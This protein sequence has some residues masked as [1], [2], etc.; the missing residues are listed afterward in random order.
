VSKNERRKQV[1]KFSK[2]I[3]A[4]YNQ[5][6]SLQR[7]PPLLNGTIADFIMY[8]QKQAMEEATIRTKYKVY[9]VMLRDKVNLENP[10][11]VKLYIARRKQWSTGHK[12]IAC[13]AYNDYAKM[14][15]IQWEVPYY[16]KN[17]TLPI[18]PTE[19]EIDALIA[20]TSRK[21]SVTLQALKE[22]GF[23]IGELYSCKWT[24]LDEEKST[25][26]CVSEK[27]GRPREAKIS[28]RLLARIN[29]LPRNGLLIFGTK[30]IGG[31]RWT[32]DK[33]KKKLAEKLQNPRLTQIHFHTM[34]HYYATKVYNETKSIIEVQAKLGHRNIN[35]T[36]VYTHIMQFDEE[37]QNYHHAVARD[38]KEAGELI[39]NG[40]TYILTTPQN[41]M[42]FRKRK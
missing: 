8:C 38:E 16:K 18:V 4:G 11:E 30:N 2:P 23:R 14:R 24:D 26:R 17:E 15:R 31:I 32:L 7:N 21:V 13:Y 40:W 36:M 34:R 20:G 9:K 39:D 41:I 6:T 12:I 29:S 28:T 22:T 25:L 5:H 37:S 3:L 35:S 42:M 10:E 33:Q 19:K 27:H 1:N